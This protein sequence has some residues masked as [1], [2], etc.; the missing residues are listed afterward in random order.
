MM[1]HL[2][3]KLEIYQSSKIADRLPQMTH[4]AHTSVHN[5]NEEESTFHLPTTIILFTHFNRIGARNKMFEKLK[6][7]FN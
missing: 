5:D 6:F 3:Y 7:F 1:K 2:K 4:T